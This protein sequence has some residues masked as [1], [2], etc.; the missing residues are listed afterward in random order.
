MPEWLKKQKWPSY[1]EALRTVHQPREYE[2][3]L[4]QATRPQAS[5][6]MMNCWPANWRWH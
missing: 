1:A 6:I 5:G 4:P 3:L 2:D